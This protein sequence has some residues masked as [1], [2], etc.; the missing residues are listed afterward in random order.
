MA[1]VSLIL[2][3][4]PGVDASEDRIVPFRRVL[5]DA[6]HQVEMIVVADPRAQPGSSGLGESVRTLIAARPGMA[7]ATLDGLREAT[8]DLL[9]VIELDRGYTPKGLISVVEPVARG[10]AE[11]AVASRHGERGFWGGPSAWS[12][13]MA[14][15][16]LGTSD[17]SSGLVALT[18]KAIPATNGHR[19]PVGS[20]FALELL[21]RAGGRRVDVPIRPRPTYGWTRYELDDLRHIKRLADHRFGNASRLFQFCVVGASGMVIDLTSYALFQLVLSRTVLARLP[22][23]WTGGSCDLAIAGALAIAI[24]LVWNFSL[25]RRLTFNDSREGSIARQFATYVLGNA[26][27]IALSYTLRMVLPVRVAFFGRHRLAAALVGIVAATGIS[28]SMSRWVVFSRRAGG[29]PS[30]AL[31]TSEPPRAEATSV[32]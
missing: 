7:V 4:A 28:F 17:P 14:R 26:L 5:E 23:P 10:E 8:G 20:R 31:Q 18:R 6:G 32:R 21:A 3:V 25:N 30:S 22:A 27:A 9:V 12:G 2:P 13:T 24:A 1:R 29:G 11:L 15:G 19:S 16:F